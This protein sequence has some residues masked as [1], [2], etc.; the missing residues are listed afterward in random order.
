MHLLNYFAADRN[1]FVV[2]FRLFSIKVET[3]LLAEVR[4]AFSPLLYAESAANLFLSLS[5]LLDVIVLFAITRSLI[6]QRH[7]ACEPH[8]LCKP[9]TDSTYVIRRT[10]TIMKRAW[11]FSQ[12]LVVF[13]YCFFFLYTN[14][15][16]S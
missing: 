5:A 13:Y 2:S 6:N 10:H 14:T 9:R 7:P 1:V 8:F 4:K 11:P 12:C 3:L 16:Y 15:N